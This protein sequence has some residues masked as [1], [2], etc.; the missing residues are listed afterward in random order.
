MWTIFGP[1]LF[2]IAFAVLSAYLLR[3]KGKQ[4]NKPPTKDQYTVPQADETQS[5]PKVYGTRQIEGY[6]NLHWKILD[7]K[8]VIQ[9]VKGLLWTTKTP[10]GQW[11]TF[12]DI[13]CG[14]CFADVGAKVY[15]KEIYADDKLVWSNPSSIAGDVMGGYINAKDFFADDDD[16]YGSFDFYSGSDDQTMSAYLDNGIYGGNASSWPK[17]SHMIFKNFK[18]TSS[19]SLPQIKLVV[20]HQPVPSFLSPDVAAWDGKSNPVVPIYYSQTDYISGAGVPSSIFDLENYAAV[21]LKLRNDNFGFCLIRQFSRS[22]QEDLDDM[23]ETI[24]GNFYTDGET[25]KTC[26]SLN[27]SSYDKNTIP[28]IT[29]KDIVNYSSTRN[30]LSSQVDEVRVKY[31]DVS[32]GYK[33]LTAGYKNPS[34]RL[35]KGDSDFH[36]FNYGMIPDYDTAFKVAYRE[37]VPLSN[38]LITLS[39]EMNRKLSNNKI[40]DPVLITIDK[41]GIIEVPFRIVKINYG[42][43]KASTMKVDLVQDRFGDFRQVFDDANPSGEV[44]RTATALNCQLKV[45]TAPAYFNKAMSIQDNLVLA[46]A[47]KPNGRHLGF[48]LWT[49][50][51]TTADFIRNGKSPTFSLKATLSANITNRANTMTV[52]GNNFTALSYQ[53]DLLNQGYNMGVLIDELNNKIEFVNFETVTESGGVYTLSAVNRGLLDTIPKDFNMLT[54]ELYLF[55]YGVAMNDT[56]FFLDGESVAMKALTYTSNEILKIEDATQLNYTIA[57]RKDKPINVSNLKVNTMPFENNMFIGPI[58]LQLSWSFR[59]QIG[60]IQYYDEANTLNSD[61]NNVNIKLYDSSNVLIKEVTLTASETSWVF[62][63]ELIINSGVRY[64]YIKAVITSVKSSINSLENYNIII[65]RA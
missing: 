45:L 22:I 9:K 2:S 16:L 30:S 48:D 35:K 40:G 33:E 61:Q 49:D 32:R 19:T 6:Q 44:D 65:T 28:K 11:Q 50:S 37:S 12:A 4:K 18:I 41:I 34:T 59:N 52:V 5:V 55:S 39:L 47:E 62:D 10:T 29:T 58:D 14:I 43:L 46:F 60:S 21:A 3:D 51:S 13:H 26:I 57:N 53:R 31:I 1:M 64:N 7:Q 24:D 20:A 15:L 36:E 56:D 54:T 25:G 27:S 17:L 42:K 8:E 38:S 23:L 63:D